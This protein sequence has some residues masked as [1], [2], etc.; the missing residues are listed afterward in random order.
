MVD[1]F[2]PPPPARVEAQRAASQ[3]RLQAAR[4][5]NAR[6]EAQRA[7]APGQVQAGS[8]E[9]KQIRQQEAQDKEQA[10]FNSNYQQR[11]ESSGEFQ[12]QRDA[13]LK[14][15][16]FDYGSVRTSFYSPPKHL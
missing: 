7:K 9:D 1:E 5:Y 12:A 13:A 10:S 14:S 8:F 2:N 4:D 3:A 16:R 15:G 11:A 6:V